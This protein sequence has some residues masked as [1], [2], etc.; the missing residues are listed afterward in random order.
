M[1]VGERGEPGIGG[2]RTELR[3]VKAP[4]SED[5]IQ[6]LETSSDGRKRKDVLQKTDSKTGFGSDCPIS[7]GG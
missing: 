6:V 3:M 5:P 1:S 2:I 7:I 4:R